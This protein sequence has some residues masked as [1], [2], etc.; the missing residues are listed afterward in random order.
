VRSALDHL[1]YHAAWADQG[2][3]QG[4][5]QFP[6]TDLQSKWY[7]K[8]V[9][10]QLGGMSHQHATWIES[11]QPFLGVKWTESLQAL[12]NADKHRV[13]IGV[14][15]TIVYELDPDA[16]TVDPDNPQGLVTRIAKVRVEFLLPQL[17]P[18]GNAA[19]MLL[20]DIIVNAGE[21]INKFLEES[22]VPQ[23]T[24]EK[25]EGAA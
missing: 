21:L 11:V 25:R 24:I 16:V 9:K 5:T 14:S 12:S 17:E 19:E 6:I 1:V 23:F 18:T 8:G 2:K 4:R 13:G 22:G 3:P 15:P 10:I 20:D 7:G